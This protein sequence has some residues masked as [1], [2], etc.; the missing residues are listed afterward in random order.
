ILCRKHGEFRQTPSTH[1]GSKGKGCPICGLLKRSQ[2]RRYTKE[3][4][5]NLAQQK[6]PG[7]LYDYKDVEYSGVTKPVKIWCNKHNQAFMQTPSI[8]L[9]EKGC[10]RCGD[11]RSVFYTPER[12]KASGLQDDPATLYLIEMRSQNEHFIKVGLH[13]KTIKERF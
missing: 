6:H 1:L 5:I 4:F 2:K 7:S 13:R 9:A 10:P 3:Q 12:V 11:E 8:H